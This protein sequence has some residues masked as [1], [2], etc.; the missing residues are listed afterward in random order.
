MDA[1][2]SLYLLP[3]LYGPRLLLRWNFPYL[4]QRTRF[5]MN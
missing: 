3:L 4:R 1:Q 2:H 5:Q